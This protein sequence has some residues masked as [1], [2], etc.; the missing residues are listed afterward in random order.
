MLHQYG[1]GLPSDLILFREG[2]DGN[3]ATDVRGRRKKE[4]QQFGERFTIA[5]NTYYPELEGGYYTN[6]ALLDLIYVGLHKLGLRLVVSYLYPSTTIIPIE[7]VGCLLVGESYVVIQ[8]NASPIGALELFEFAAGGGGEYY[9]D[10]V[11][12]DFVLPAHL[13]ESMKLM[14]KSACANL[15]V[16]FKEYPPAASVPSNAGWLSRAFLRVRGEKG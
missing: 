12:C 6:R 14:L 10:R 4:M 11:I 8:E 13:R 2:F 9:R 16:Q 7:G 1:P 15:S 5:V 3:E